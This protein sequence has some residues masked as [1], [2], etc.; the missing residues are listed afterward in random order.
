MD[1]GPSFVADEEAAKLVQPGEGAL[2]DPSQ[3]SEAG[4]VRG[5]LAGDQGRDAALAQ[6]QPVAAVVVPAVADELAG[7][8]TWTADQPCDRGD[9]IDERD[10]LGDVVAVAAGEGEGERE[11]GRL[12]DQVVLGAQ[13]STVNRARA[14]L[15]TPFF[16]CT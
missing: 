4:A 16:A 2:D 5:L 12:D 14:R 7:T 13:A 10:Q 11:T 8:A 6:R 3:A 9:P 1:L 15:G